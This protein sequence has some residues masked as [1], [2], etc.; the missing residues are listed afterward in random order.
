MVRQTAYL[1]NAVHI[2]LNVTIH[3]TLAHNTIP[4]SLP[5]NTI[6]VLFMGLL[7]AFSNSSNINKL[8]YCKQTV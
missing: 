8:N 7:S 1:P 4:G 2:K 6:Q 5:H 3:V